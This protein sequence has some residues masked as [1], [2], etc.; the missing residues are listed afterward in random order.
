MTRSP[1]VWWMRGVLILTCTGVSFAHGTNDGQKSIG[2][3]MLTIIGLFPAVFALNPEAIGWVLAAAITA[4]QSRIRRSRQPNGPPGAT[5][6]LR[7]AK[8]Y[9]SNE[10]VL[11]SL[12][13]G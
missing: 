10:G 4:L 6:T 11:R 5:T 1:P 9:P 2:L 7:V 12:T 8:R 13:P 3:I